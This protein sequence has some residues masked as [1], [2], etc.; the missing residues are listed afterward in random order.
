[1]LQCE[2]GRVAAANE[3][4]EPLKQHRPVVNVVGKPP[5]D[6]QPL[7]QRDVVR[8]L[9]PTDVSEN[10]KF[11]CASASLFHHPR[12]CREGMASREQNAAT[13]DETTS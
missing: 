1:M 9:G 6:A 3:L 2:S 5:P 10:M 7:V 4:S 11:A 8:R 12:T 13:P